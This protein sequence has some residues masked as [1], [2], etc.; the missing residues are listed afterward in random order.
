M[1]YFIHEKNVKLFTAHHIFTEA[2]MHSRYEI[3]LENY[4]KNAEY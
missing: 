4:C 3:I 1:P 2:E